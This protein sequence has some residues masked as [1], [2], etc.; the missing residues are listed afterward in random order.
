LA[1]LAIFL[2]S[3]SASSLRSVLNTRTAPGKALATWKLSK[4]ANTARVSLSGGLGIN[5]YAGVIR[6]AVEGM[7]IAEMP[8]ILCQR[9]FQQRLLVPVM[10]NWRFEQ[11][12]LSAYYLSR[13]HPSRLV[14]LFLVHCSAKAESCLTVSGESDP[15]HGEPSRTQRARVRRRK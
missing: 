14:E 8:S 11:V 2:I 12:D 6:A 9:E 1:I 5:D 13:R 15:N 7:G 10:A 3:N 4:G